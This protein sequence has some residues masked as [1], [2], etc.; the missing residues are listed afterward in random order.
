M[1]AL[2]IKMM[3]EKKVISAYNEQE[4]YGRLNKRKFT[5]IDILYKLVGLYLQMT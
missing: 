2:I 1:A 3:S 4:V 5:R